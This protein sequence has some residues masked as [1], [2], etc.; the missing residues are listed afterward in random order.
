MYLVFGVVFLVLAVVSTL[1][2]VLFN[3]SEKS[4]KVEGTRVP[5]VEDVVSALQ[6]H[7]NTMNKS[8]KAVLGVEAAI[9]QIQEKGYDV[10]TPLEFRLH[11]QAIRHKHKN[12]YPNGFLE[13]ADILEKIISEGGGESSDNAG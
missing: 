2:V 3:L 9:K 4:K 11:A 10:G 1:L 6:A 7:V 13:A 12:R 8:S 5:P